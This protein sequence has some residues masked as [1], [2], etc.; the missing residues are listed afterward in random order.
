MEYQPASTAKTMQS[1][2]TANGTENVVGKKAAKTL[3]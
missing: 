3:A 2:A 1:R